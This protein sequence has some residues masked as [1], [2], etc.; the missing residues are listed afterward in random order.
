MFY[1]IILLNEVRR[2]MLLF[3]D[4]KKEMKYTKN[5]AFDIVPNA[6]ITINNTK[7]SIIND[8]RNSMLFTI[9]LDNKIF[10]K[11]TFNDGK[12]VQ[13]GQRLLFNYYVFSVYIYNLYIL[14][15]IYI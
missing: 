3:Y 15:I 5:I 2:I 1:V 7:L 8:L 13:F 6:L 11:F 14:Y 10:Y 4:C 9:I 12:S